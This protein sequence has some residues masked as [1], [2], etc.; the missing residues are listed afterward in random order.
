MAGASLEVLSAMNASQV[1]GASGLVVITRVVASQPGSVEVS[2]YAVD[3]GGCD[4]LAGSYSYV[5]ELDST[6][7]FDW[8]Q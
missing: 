2:T 8:S 1:D 6:V 3:S 5:V 4:V 7:A